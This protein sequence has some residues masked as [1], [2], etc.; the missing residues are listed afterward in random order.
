M[1]YDRPDA[2]P[3]H[4]LSPIFRGEKHLGDFNPQDRLGII[5]AAQDEV[6]EARGIEELPNSRISST[7]TTGELSGVYARATLLGSKKLIEIATRR[8]TMPDRRNSVPVLSSEDL[9]AAVMPKFGNVIARY[10]HHRTGPWGKFVISRTQPMMQLELNKPDAVKA[11]RQELTEFLLGYAGRRSASDSVADEVADRLT[12]L[13][14]YQSLPWERLGEAEKLVVVMRFGLNGGK[15]MST[16]DIGKEL[17]LTRQ[18]VER[19]LKI[20]AMV[21]RGEARP[22]KSKVAA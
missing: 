5:Y 18:A 12:A 21:L 16:A 3:E 14:R 2:V 8:F 17:G 9:V 11:R 15:E 19:R 10:D 13:Q 7:V 6:Y 22:T 1:S 20:A 4:Q